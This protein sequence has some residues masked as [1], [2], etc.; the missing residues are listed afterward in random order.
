MQVRL[1]LTHGM[2]LNSIY[3][4]GMRLNSVSIVCASR[5]ASA[6]ADTTFEK[7]KTEN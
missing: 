5:R 6:D 2:R 3:P 1:H 7:K 4:Y